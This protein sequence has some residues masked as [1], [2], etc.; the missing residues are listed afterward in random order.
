MKYTFLFVFFLSMHSL[1]A[2]N[3]FWT[4]IDK[5]LIQQLVA[6]HKDSTHLLEDYFE[7]PEITKSKTNLGFGWTVWSTSRAGGYITISS[8]FYYYNDSLI[9]FQINPSLPDELPLRNKYIKWYNNYFETNQNNELTR[10]SFNIKSL[11]L[12][13]KNS[14]DT[15]KSI[16]L[17]NELINLM[18][19]TSNLY[20]YWVGGYEQSMPYNRKLFLE[21][22][23]NISFEELKFMTYSINPIT[24]FMAIEEIIRRNYIETKCTSKDLEWY[25]LCFKEIPQV[26][27]LNGCIGRTESSKSLVYFF[28]QMR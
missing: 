16:H 22:T 20:Y 13:L 8:N 11:C 5:K 7:K 1:S 2:N 23:N 25:E 3:P 18:I 24:R 6:I 12:P 10:Y 19:P 26:K 9:A 28:S 4:Q 17:K 15:L 21:N 27:T 14:D